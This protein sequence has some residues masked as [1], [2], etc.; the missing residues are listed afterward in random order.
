MANMFSGKTTKQIPT[1]LNECRQEDATVNNL[2]KWAERLENWGRSLFVILIII[3][4]ICTIIDTVIM[5]DND[6]DMA[7]A[8][9]IS[10]VIT[11]G[12]Y[13]FIEY[14]AYHVLALLISALASITQNTIVSANVALYEA[15][16]RYT[17][18][19]STEPVPDGMWV[20]YHCGTHNSINYGQ[21]KKCG[22]F[23]S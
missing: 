2:H 6:E 3:G 5:L 22:K 9:C 17:N 11:W 8:T 19:T 1:S 23:K 16:K 20:C 10:S 7:L 14:C 21:C 4:I 15:S 12:L 13:A 18:P